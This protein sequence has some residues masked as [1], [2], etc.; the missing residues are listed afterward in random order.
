MAS[1]IDSATAS[2]ARWMES[3][4][5]PGS[6]TRN[7]GASQS[8]A[9]ES[10]HNRSMVALTSATVAGTRTVYRAVPPSFAFSAG[11]CLLFPH[12]RHVDQNRDHE[13]QP[14]RH[15]HAEV[16]GTPRAV[17]PDPEESEQ[18]AL[19]AEPRGGGGRQPVADGTGDHQKRKVHPVDVP[20]HSPALHQ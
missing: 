11:R 3:T 16:R 8:S 9:P 10:G 13:G 7:P 14:Q 4:D 15:E 20:I 17:R 19:P 1:S 18:I 12:H 5:A 2:T 6:P